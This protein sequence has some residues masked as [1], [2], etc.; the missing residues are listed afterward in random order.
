MQTVSADRGDEHDSRDDDGH[1]CGWSWPERAHVPA[2]PCVP[3]TGALPAQGLDGV[4]RA[5]RPRLGA[6]GTGRSRRSGPR[7]SRRPSPVGPRPA[8][9]AQHGR[10]RPCVPRHRVPGWDRHRGSCGRRRAAL[11]RRG[12]PGSAPA[13][14][15]AGPGTAGAALSAWAGGRLPWRRG[16]AATRTRRGCEA[17]RAPAPAKRRRPRLTPAEPHPPSLIRWSLQEIRRVATRLAQQRIRPAHVIAWRF[18]D[19]R[20]KPPRNAHI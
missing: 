14:T 11:G 18:G 8:G 12:R 4:T 1:G 2:R 20:T 7:R 5:A 16:A 10:R 13:T 9:P 6:R 17:G 19:A 3:R 15:S